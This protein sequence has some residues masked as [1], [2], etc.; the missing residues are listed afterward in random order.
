MPKR[1]F[2]TYNSETD[3][4]E[5]YYPTMR[6]RLRRLGTGVLKAAIYGGLVYLAAFYIFDSPTE[7][8]LRKENCEL[9]KE[10]ALLG[11]RLNSALGVMEDIRNRDDNFYRVMM[12]MEPIEETRRYAGLANG[13]QYKRFREMDDASI[14][15]EV[16]RNMDLLDREIYTQSKS[17]DE[18]KSNALKN[19]EQA[20]HTPQILPLPPGSFTI[21]SG[22]GYRRDP[23]YGTMKFH[24]GL[25]LAAPSGTVVRSTAK[26][27]VVRASQD[28]KEGLIAVVDHGNGYQSSYAH[29]G[30]L[31]VKEGE[32][33]DRGSQLGKVGISNSA[34][35]AF[36]HYSVN[37]HGEPQNPADYC[38]MELDPEQYQAFVKA[39]GNSGFVMER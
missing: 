26:G 37:Y 15:G 39:A 27:K 29:L 4:Y 32:E 9:K 35:G 19:R 13:E 1:V 23:V 28:R 10:Y 38:F 7:A 33:V 5:R 12:Q 34:N 11:K 8:N 22:F 16:M 31:T 2:Y 6:D 17:F 36:I 18:L 20:L 30:Q 14:V 24:D 3:D 25:D 21:A